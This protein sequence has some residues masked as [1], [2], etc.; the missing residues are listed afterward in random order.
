MERSAVFLSGLRSYLFPPSWLGQFS[1][2]TLFCLSTTSYRTTRT[3]NSA[4]ERHRERQAQSFDD[5]LKLFDIV[6]VTLV[7]GLSTIFMVHAEQTV[8]LAQF[9]SMRTKISDFVIFGL[10]LFLCHLVLGVC[11]SMVR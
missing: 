6:L 5:F 8:S 3:L 4:R 11:G 10:T 1:G 2:S 9:L 7:F